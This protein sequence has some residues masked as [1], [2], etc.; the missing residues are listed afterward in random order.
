MKAKVSTMGL[1]A[2]LDNI[3]VADVA[4][5]RRRLS[6]VQR[7]LQRGQPADQLLE[8]LQLRM[9]TSGKKVDARRA[10]LPQ[11][12]FDDGLPITAHRQEILGALARHQVIIVAGETGSGKTTQLRT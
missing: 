12:Q 5:C 6:D 9:E 10:G 8:Q 7:R 4:W 1:Q 11:P 3:M 2:K